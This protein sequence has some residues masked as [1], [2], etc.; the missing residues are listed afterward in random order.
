MMMMMSSYDDTLVAVF[1]WCCA[2]RSPHLLGLL[3]VHLTGCHIRKNNV[4]SVTTKL[5]FVCKKCSG[6]GKRSMQSR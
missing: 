3:D 6:T 2:L 1:M 5:W 4:V